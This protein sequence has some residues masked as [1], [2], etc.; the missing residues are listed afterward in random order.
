[1]YLE[2]GTHNANRAERAMETLKQGTKTNLDK[3]NAPAVFW[4]HA[5]EIRAAIKNAIVRDNM[6][7]Q[8]QYPEIVMTEQPIDI[9]NISDFKVWEWVKYKKEGV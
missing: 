7:C 4:C 3:S 6:H 9:S 5:L 2:K 8:G 1:M